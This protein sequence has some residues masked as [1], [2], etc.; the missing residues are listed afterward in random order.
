MT[1]NVGFIE[2]FDPYPSVLS[3]NAGVLGVWNLITYSGEPGAL[4]LTLGFTGV[5]QC[6]TSD[7]V[8]FGGTIT[9][10][11]PATQHLSM[12][13]GFRLENGA[14][15]YDMTESIGILDESGNTQFSIGFNTLGRMTL[16]GEG[17]VTLWTSDKVFD[18][19]VIYRCNMTVDSSVANA[20][21]VNLWET[22][23]KIINNVTMDLQDSASQN[24]AAMR[25][26][27]A[28]TQLSLF[29]N[30]KISYDDIVVLYGDEV[31]NLG[32]TG[33]YMIG[34]TADILHQ[35]TP[36]TGATNYP[37]VD[38]LPNNRDTDY[39]S[40]ETVG[41]RDT[42]VMANLTRS[43]D[44]IH[45]VSQL[46]VARKEESGT[47]TIKHVLE[48]GATEQLGHNANL[49]QSYTYIFDHYAKN[50]DGNV[51]WNKAA[52]DALTS[53]YEDVL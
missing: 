20:T 6:L 47:R 16:K 38:D 28:N 18:G 1:V 45:Y 49:S 13:F 27:I 35:W 37:N 39:N 10:G 46:T 43:P 7:A 42:F 24:M 11:F 19:G 51:E 4:S 21:V 31:V 25:I 12:A 5:G 15:P 29:K 44:K 2:G 9:R 36:S 41:F 33:I 34:P 50:P 23:N 14:S 48:S 40:S 30:W 26:T 17:G 22:G 32:E 53:G 52:V 8:L 3:A